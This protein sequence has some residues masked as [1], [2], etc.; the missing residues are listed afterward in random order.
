[1]STEAAKTSGVRL[2]VLGVIQPELTLSRPGVV[3][4]VWN[5]GYGDIL[6]EVFDDGRVAVN[7]K[8]VECKATPNNTC[9]T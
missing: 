6:I 3:S 8:D 4:Y 1:M 5:L 2:N 9:T 7:E